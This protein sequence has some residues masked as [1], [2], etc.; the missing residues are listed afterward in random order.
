MPWLTR[1]FAWRPLRFSGLISYSLYIWH[2]MVIRLLQ[3]PLSQ[4]QG[5]SARVL[6]GI[7]LGVAVSVPLAYLWYQIVERP[8]LVRKAPQEQSAGAPAG[9]ERHAIATSARR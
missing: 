1:F 3:L 4:V 9:A 7:T 2:Y 6:L 5:M 8:F